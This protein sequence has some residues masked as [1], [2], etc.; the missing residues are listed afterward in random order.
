MPKFSKYS[1]ESFKDLQTLAGERVLKIRA[2]DGIKIY[3]ENSW[4]LARKS[5]TEPIIKLYAET[6]KGVEH[7]KEIIA[8]SSKLFGF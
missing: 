6:F 4:V 5:G 7:L 3:L 2:T 8:E 1:A